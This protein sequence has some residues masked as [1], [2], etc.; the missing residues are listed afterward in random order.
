MLILH[1]PGPLP[2]WC[3]APTEIHCLARDA[4][5][6]ITS[7]ANSS[8]P[9]N[10]SQIYI[11]ALPA[12]PIANPVSQCYL[13][14]IQSILCAEGLGTIGRDPALLSTWSTDSAIL[15][16]SISLDGTRILSISESET[17]NI[18]LW[19]SDSGENE[20]PEP[21]VSCGGV[22][23]AVAFSSNGRYVA[24]D[25]TD[26]SVAIFDLQPRKGSAR[27][28][29]CHIAPCNSIVLSSDSSML[30]FG[31]DDH[32]V[33]LC[34]AKSQPPESPTHRIVCSHDGPV[35]SVAF[36]PDNTL[37]ASGSKD[38]TICVSNIKQHQGVN[39]ERLRGHTGSVNSVAFS[40]NGCFVASGSDD[41]TIRVWTMRSHSSQRMECSLYGSPI[42]GHT[43]SVNSVAFS[44]NSVHIVS[45]SSDHTVCVWN[46][47][48]GIMVAGPF[49]G[50]T[51]PVN[52][53][54][55]MPDGTRVVSG[56]EDG[57]LRVWDTEEQDA[58]IQLSPEEHTDRTVFVQSK[59][60]VRTYLSPIER[61][62]KLIVGL[63]HIIN[64]Q[65]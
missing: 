20:V 57:T 60:M 17:Q 40:P 61:I 15:S 25:F 63:I 19:D 21:F 41:C 14:R 18:R 37:I 8:L 4:C 55:F 11:S 2:Q 38:H 58:Y 48:T 50:H 54:L 30:A 46:V 59:E 62:I 22:V 45:G 12:W 29:E 1:A 13:G 5:E 23:K 3:H 28:F 34:L 42:E 43:N 56:S 36:S 47:Q 7:F 44:P 65:H 52:S 35:S 32:T 39:S 53:V 49:Y 33:Q 24:S 26:H 51:K 6:F 27:K 31:L 16:V 10:T 9:T 64:S